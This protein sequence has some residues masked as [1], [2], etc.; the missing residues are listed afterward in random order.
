MS[1]Y[2]LLNMFMYTWLAKYFYLYSFGQGAKWSCLLISSLNKRTS[3]S[4]TARGPMLCVPFK[5]GTWES[6]RMIH[7]LFRMQEL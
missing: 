2:S 3:G 4:F 1:K 6:C 5:K 7:P